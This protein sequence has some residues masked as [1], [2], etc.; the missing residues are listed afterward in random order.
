VERGG[1]PPLIIIKG[2]RMEEREG[3][4]IA[5]KLSSHLTSWIRFLLLAKGKVTVT[6]GKRG[7]KK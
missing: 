1:A 4:A 2:K 6:G 7:L 5:T 3:Q